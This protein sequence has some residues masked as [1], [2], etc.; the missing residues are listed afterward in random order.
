MSTEQPNPSTRPGNIIPPPQTIPIVTHHCRYCTNLIL[1]TTRDLQTLPR[2]D[3]DVRDS[4]TILPLRN[5]TFPSTH[6]TDPA[7]TEPDGTRHYTI[8]LSSG[9]KDKKPV[10]VRRADG[11]EKRFFLRCGR[12]KLVMGYFLDPLHFGPSRTTSEIEAEKAEGKPRAQ[13]E[14]GVAD[15][16]D[17]AVFLLPGALFETEQMSDEE[18]MRRMDEEWSTWFKL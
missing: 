3:K 12:C 16:D 7:Q 10:I 13:I 4:A 8:I 15:P 9:T 2:R 17:Q 1:A 18:K 6:P 11:F 5:I 14:E